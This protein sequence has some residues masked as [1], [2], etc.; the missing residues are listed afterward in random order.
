M[1]KP[2]T[3][4]VAGATGRQGG[5]VARA[6][7]ARGH[8]VRALTRHPD[9]PAAKALALQR[10]EVVAGDFD[11]PETV[12]RACRGCDAAF[13]VTTPAEQGPAAETRQGIAALEAAK[14]A[15]VKHLVYS[16]AAGAD[17]RTGIAHF[18][19]KRAVEEHLA[20]MGV[21]WTVLAPVF[22]MENL[23]SPA[24]GLGEGRLAMPLPPRRR[25]QQ[26]AL[27]DLGKLAAITCERRSATEGLR[28]EV[29]SDELTGA[30]AAR[31]LGHACGREIPYRQ[32]DL[33][34]L[35]A[36]SADAAR[37]FEWLGEVGFGLDVD[38]LRREHLDVPWHDFA[39]WAHAQ[40][41]DLILPKAEDAPS[42]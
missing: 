25:L 13:V 3:V 19:S 9:G 8:R 12:A 40:E 2:I 27:A 42:A 14:R 22:F 15:G 20:G 30:E 4:L 37:M 7:L 10:A 29:A 33:E 17:R 32:V 11:V 24:F 1:P 26:V 36:Q 28:V 39:V 31:I 6:L 16:S 35:H 41:W 23:L 18:D 21:P 34:S 38:A 5:A